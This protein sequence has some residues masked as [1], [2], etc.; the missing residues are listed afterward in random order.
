MGHKVGMVP[1]GTT[2]D[3]TPNQYTG[4][5]HV[6]SHCHTGLAV[7]A[8][9]SGVDGSTCVMFGA[10]NGLSAFCADCARAAKKVDLSAG[11]SGF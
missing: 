11:W 4:K 1:D 9:Y 8:T 6:G 3:A 2:L 10:T 7:L 5:G